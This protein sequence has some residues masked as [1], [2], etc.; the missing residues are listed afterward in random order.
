M[1]WN[2]IVNITCESANVNIRIDGERL[3]VGYRKLG[4]VAQVGLEPT[5][6]FQ[7]RILNP[8]RLPISSLSQDDSITNYNS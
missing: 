2:N 6:C 7:D 1:I 3:K 8:A 5:P 4:V